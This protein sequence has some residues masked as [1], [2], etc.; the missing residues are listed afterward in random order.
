M[1][2]LERE[3]FFQRNGP[4]FGVLIGYGDPH[5]DRMF[6]FLKVFRLDAILHDP[7]GAVYVNN[8]QDTVI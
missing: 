4:F 6:C 2:L 8:G 3:H 5:S 1:S 7:A